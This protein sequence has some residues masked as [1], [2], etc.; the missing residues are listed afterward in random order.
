ME[1]QTFMEPWR[2][3]LRSIWANSL[4]LQI[5]FVL[6]NQSQ[7]AQGICSVAKPFHSL[8]I[9]ARVFQLETQAVRGK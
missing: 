8:G 7:N 6:G 3:A 4:T 2:L 9:L 5:R 1:T